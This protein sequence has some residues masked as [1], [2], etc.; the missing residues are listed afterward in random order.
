MKVTSN[1]QVEGY[2][3]IISG[4]LDIRYYVI[5]P[6]KPIGNCMS[7]LSFQP[8][9]LFYI[10]SFWIVLTVKSYYFLKQH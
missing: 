10:N 6:L 2:C 1:I 9:T 4:T 8:I 3:E 5:N 7:Q